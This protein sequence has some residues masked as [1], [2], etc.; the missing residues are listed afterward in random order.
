MRSHVTFLSDGRKVAGHLYRPDGSTAGPRPAV[1]VVHPFGGV[2]EQTAGLYARSLADA[3]F[4]TLAFDASYQGESEGLPRYLEDPF[5]RA[6]DIKSAVGFLTTRG[7]VDAERI[8]ALGICAGGGYVTYAAQTD[9]RVKAVASVSGADIGG[10]F[11]DGLGGGRDRS[12]LRGMLDAAA[13]DR[14]AEAKGA[15]PRLE[16]IVPETEADAEGFPTLYQ[17]GRDYYRT[18]RARHPH[19]PN[20]FVARSVDRIAQYSSFGLIELIAPRP[21]LMIAGTEAD[22]AYFSREAV[23]SATGPKELYEVEGATHIDLYDKA[24]YLPQVTTK[25]HG[26][27][28]SALGDG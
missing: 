6:E 21:L 18:P 13:A 11:R 26:F 16:R 17:E 24:E 23:A 25:L 7:E 12:V 1:V 22:T 19:A 4:V 14:T 9:H 27:F 8:G 2:K 20:W 10:L 5:A 28:R 3:G 15:E